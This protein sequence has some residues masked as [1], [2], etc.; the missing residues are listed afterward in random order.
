MGR[1]D[2]PERTDI[3][4]ARV[5]LLHCLRKVRKNEEFAGFTPII[6]D[7]INNRRQDYVAFSTER[8]GKI[9][10]SGKKVHKHD[11]RR[12][13]RT[14]LHRYIIRNYRNYLIHNYI[15]ERDVELFTAKVCSY[16][17]NVKDFQLVTGM[18]IES[19]YEQEL[20]EHSCMTG[21]MA[22]LVR[23]YCE[24][25]DKVALLTFDTGFH[26]GRALIWT[27]N[28]GT[29]I[30]DRIYPNDDVV[31]NA[32]KDYAQ[33]KG[34]VS[35]RYNNLDAS[36]HVELTDDG[37]YEVTLSSSTNR[38]P[39]MDTFKFASGDESH[40]TLSNERQFYHVARLESTQGSFLEQECCCC[41][42][43]FDSLTE[44]P[45]GNM[46]CEE[47]YSEHWTYSNTMGED[48]HCE[49]A[50]YVEDSGDY[51]TLEYAQAND[52]QCQ[53]C[54][55]VNE[56]NEQT[57]AEETFCL[58]CFDKNFTK[59]ESCDDVTPHECMVEDI[60]EVCYEEQN[61]DE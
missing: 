8:S 3:I 33:N 10:Y 43:F 45:S 1:K 24:N 22:Y 29:K 38:W 32:F 60:C 25:P 15:S 41:S 11:N 27:T 39:Y 54:G 6:N 36:D 56:K 21:E 34:W 9:A 58:Y 26:S 12:R 49:D 28:C 44:A 53:C 57:P 35:R 18:D 42:D 46:Y 13:A 14:T 37:T 59:C 16:T 2:F 55:D 48:I 23:I 51:V 7:I 61:S 31:K 17:S 47:C 20:G 5:R 19:A 4:R 50:Y 40:A 52:M 30:M